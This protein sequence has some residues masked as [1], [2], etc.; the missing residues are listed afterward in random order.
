[1]NPNDNK[2]NHSGGKGSGNWR[3]IVSLVC[4]ALLLTIIINSATAYLGSAGHQSSS[5]TLEYSQF[6]D[7]VKAGDVEY[8]EFS[9]SENILLI[10]P[11]E[12]YVYTDPQGVTYTR[13]KDCYTITDHT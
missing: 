9:N 5:V 4:W 3:G 12:G 11:E 7:M 8:V 2:N 1:M 6:T 10:T 13:T